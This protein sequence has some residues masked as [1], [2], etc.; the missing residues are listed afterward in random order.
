VCARERRA[1]DGL[2]VMA[3]A[4]RESFG[5]PLTRW[6]SISAALAADAP[7]PPDV[8]NTDQP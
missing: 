7:V 8:L 5:L 3:S 1:Y 6:D 2:L 4:E